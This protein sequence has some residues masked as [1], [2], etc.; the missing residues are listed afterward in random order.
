M[1]KRIVFLLVFS[2]SVVFCSSLQAIELYE[3][4][5]INIHG[6][7]SQGYIQSGGNGIFADTKEDG[8]FQYS[9][10]AVNFTSDVSDRL[11]LGLQLFSRDL[12][13]MG[14]HELTVD[15]AFAD[16]SF[17]DWLNLKAGKIKLPLGLY[18]T[19][20][21]VDMLR[22]F[23]FL[24]QSMYYEGWRDSSNAVNGAGFYGYIGAGF[25]GAF[26]YEGYLGNSI[27][28]PTAGV[29]RMTKDQLPAYMDMD[30][31]EVNVRY[32]NAATLTW[33]SI[34]GLDG[35]RI[36]G[37]YWVIAIDFESEYWLGDF[38]AGAISSTGIP[39]FDTDGPG[40]N[41]GLFPASQAGILGAA[42]QGYDIKVMR[43]STF[44][45]HNATSAIGLEYVYDN[46][47]FAAEA[48]QNDYKLTLD[49]PDPA[50]APVL[51]REFKTLGYYGSLT[52]RFTDWFELGTYYSEYFADKD[53]KDG[54]DAQAREQALGVASSQA[55]KKYNKDLCITARFDISANWVAKIEGHQME[56]T[57][58]LFRD[59]DNFGDDGEAFY[60]KDWY[61][62]AM[63]L[64][65]S[66]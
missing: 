52:Y 25:A 65:Y 9:E 22:T 36:V 47:V 49:N 27:V 24:P 55:F 41:P 2:L 38:N 21:D 28:S 45:I 59:D 30:F 8:S 12:G 16:Y 29:A 40:P 53:D 23:V 15:W 10:A 13:K 14:N 51:D 60:K 3:T 7:I 6:F 32:T 61:F 5:N 46:L 58:L 66:F 33:E 31:S 34:F 35:L 57:S 63:K 11:S 56:G 44:H 42:A 62:G 26:S 64:T 39:L 54:K 43:N 20:R 1:K 4:G 48:M 50:G 19:E 17:Y 37:S 18:N